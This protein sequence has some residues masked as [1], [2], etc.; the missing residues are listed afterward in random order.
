MTETAAWSRI[1]PQTGVGFRLGR[2]ATLEVMDPQGEQVADLVAF[3]ESRE[4]WLSSGRTLDYANTIYLTT[5]HTLYSNRS[6][7]MFEIVADDVTRHDFLL[8]P[9]SPEMFE[10]IYGFGP[11]HPSCF[12]NLA[13]ALAPFGVAPDRIPTAFNI[14]MNVTVAPTGE[15]AVMPPL[16]GPGD[17]ISLRAEM[18]LI[19]GLTAC[20][21]EQSNNW[22]FKPIDYRVTH[23]GPKSAG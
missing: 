8:A 16:S 5:G 10:R 1:P 23:P 20:S 15:L 9:C 13:G 11:G 3:D 18:D 19:I 22:S 4:Q 17:A 12:Q 21:A 6:E 7:P 2:G 14:F